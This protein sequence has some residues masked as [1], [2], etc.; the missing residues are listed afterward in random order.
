LFGS[1]QAR[2]AKHQSVP[3]PFL[4]YLSEMGKARC[5]E[6][7]L[8]RIKQVGFAAP[9]APHHGVGGRRKRL[10]FALLFEGPEVRYRNLL[11]V[12]DC[13]CYLFC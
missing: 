4:S 5:Q 13:W 6:T 8:H 10:D 9:V 7:E 1:A 12:H 11:D 3:P 2:I